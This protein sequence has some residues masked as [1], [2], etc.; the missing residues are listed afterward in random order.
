MQTAERYV[1]RTPGRVPAAV[2]PVA[3]RFP[4]VLK[5]GVVVS[6]EDSPALGRTFTSV[7]TRAVQ[8][9]PNDANPGSV[10]AAGRTKAL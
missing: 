9:V 8:V 5:N 1:G 7:D 10:S 2:T 6:K 4:W 3:I